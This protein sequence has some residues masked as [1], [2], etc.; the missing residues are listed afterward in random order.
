VII[1]DATIDDIPALIAIERQC[2]SAAHWSESQYHRL[3]DTEPSR[4]LSRL[5]LLVE[6]KEGG[7]Q[8]H[9]LSKPGT[10]GFLVA[11]KIDCEWELE[12]VAIA[13]GVR[14]RGLAT[15][16]L[17]ELSQRAREANGQVL[18][19]EVRESNRAAR[20]F[21]EKFG[22]NQAGR[23]KNYYDKPVEDAMLYRRTLTK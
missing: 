10:A 3:F 11:R 8:R 18:F 4:F 16:L 14:R 12:N 7:M 1:R 13:P 22:F 21:Y 9:P 15:I 2:D 17:Q 5:V 20:S 19:L 23:R 6:E